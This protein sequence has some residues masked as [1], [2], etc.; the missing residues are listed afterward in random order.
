LLHLVQK[1]LDF[2]KKLLSP[3]ELMPRQHSLCIIKSQKFKSAKFG[4]YNNCWARRR[5][6]SSKNACE[7]YEKWTRQLSKCTISRGDANF[8]VKR[9][10][11]MTK[12]RRVWNVNSLSNWVC[13]IKWLIIKAS[14]N[15][16]V[17][18]SKEESIWPF[19][20][21]QIFSLLPNVLS[22]TSKVTK[23]VDII[24]ELRFKSVWIWFDCTLSL[25]RKQTMTLWSCSID[26]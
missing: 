25:W 9:I 17:D 5:E 22:L 6:F 21:M 8:H 11:Q 26:N 1:V 2:L 18:K 19:F 16:P 7:Y 13:W 23:T 20:I 12:H 3:F 4:E 15:F 24:S 14:D 10:S